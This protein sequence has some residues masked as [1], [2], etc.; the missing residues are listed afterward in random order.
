MKKL[1]FCIPEMPTFVDVLK[2][3]TRRLDS[4]QQAS[5]ILDY[6]YESFDQVKPDSL[7]VVYYHGTL[8]NSDA[9]ELRQNYQQIVNTLEQR[10]ANVGIFYTNPND[11]PMTYWPKP[12]NVAFELSMHDKNFVTNLVREIHSALEQPHRHPNKLCFESFAS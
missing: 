11:D 2:N 7:V 6:R 12:T 9:T 8:A 3:I 1:F 5:F 4:K 10:Q